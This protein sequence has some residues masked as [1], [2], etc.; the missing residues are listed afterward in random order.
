MSN[1]MGIFGLQGSGKTMLLTTL[2][3]KD[4][5]EGSN[6]YA[7]YHLKDV[8]YTPISSLDDIE[9]IKNGTFLADELWL[10]LFSRTSQSKLN[11]ELMKIVMLNRKRNVNI[12]YTAQLSRTIDVLLREVTNYFI[13]PSIR[14]VTVNKTGEKTYRLFFV[15]QDLYG[16]LSPDYRFNGSLEYLGSFYDTTEEISELKKAEETSFEKGIQLE[17]TFS[18]ALMKVKGIRHV[19]LIPFSGSHSTWGY[20]V[21]GYF[22]GKTIAFDVKGSCQDRVYMNFFGKQLQ[23]K[24]K[25]ARSHNAIPYFA[26][27]RNDR[28]QLTNP[29]FW[30]VHHLTNTS[31]LIKLSSNPYYNKRIEN[32]EILS[33]H[34]F[35][36]NEP[37]ELCSIAPEIAL[38]GTETPVLD[39]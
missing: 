2:G 37:L 31:Y 30:Y 16:R 28:S 18:K 10:W 7:N 17:E 8:D 32:S 24:I 4:H 22:N 12:Y 23:D 21:V 1:I 15:M 39:P 38:D 6:L 34:D 36:A 29:D 26:F 9:K 5:K 33:K 3:R 27:P 13:Y 25:N 35:K 20:D 14:P 11:Q 19:E